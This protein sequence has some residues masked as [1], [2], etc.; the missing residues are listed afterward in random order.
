[1]D[2][3]RLGGALIC[4]VAIVVLGLF[5]YGVALGDPWWKWAIGVPV[6]AG[7]S[8]VML[9]GIWIGWTMFSTKVELPPPADEEEETTDPPASE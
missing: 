5:Y 2:K 4:I 1:M 9:L 6:A 7:I 8:L 3:A